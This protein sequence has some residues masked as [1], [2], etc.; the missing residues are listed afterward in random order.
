[1]LEE[2]LSNI[3]LLAL[4]VPALIRMFTPI[5]KHNPAQSSMSVQT[6]AGLLI[7]QKNIG[8][9]TKSIKNIVNVYEKPMK[10]NTICEVEGGCMS[11][12]CRVSLPYYTFDW[13]LIFYAP[14]KRSSGI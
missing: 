12:S 5:P 10:M 1:V 13:I 6:V 7:V 4:Y 11:S 8:K 3:W 2:M 9:K 14:R